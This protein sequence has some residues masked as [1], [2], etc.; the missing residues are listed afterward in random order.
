MRGRPLALLSLCLMLIPALALA[1]PPDGNAAPPRS[2]V[3]LEAAPLFASESMGTAGTIALRVSLTNHTGRDLS[4]E[5]LIQPEGWRDRDLPQRVRVDVP[6]RQQ[7][8]V[9]VSLQ[10]GPAAERV[11]LTYAPA[12]IPLQRASVALTMRSGVGLV[13]L[14]NPPRMRGHL[15]AV[16]SGTLGSPALYGGDLI[17]AETSF[18]PES[19]DPLVPDDVAGWSNYPMVFAA[20]ADAEKLEG[21]A[22]RALVGHIQA[23]GRV[24]LVPRRPEDC[25]APIVRELLGQ[26][27]CTALDELEVLAGLTQNSW[28][29]ARRF[30][31]TGDTSI[32]IEPFGVSRPLGFGTA[33]LLG[34]D[35]NAADADPSATQDL[36]R[37]LLQHHARTMRAQH[38]LGGVPED[39]ASLRTALDPN[40]SFRPALGI[41]AIL[42]LLYVLAV[43]PLNFRYVERQGRPTVALLTTPLIALGCLLLMASAAY[44]SKGV[45]MRARVIDVLELPS[46]ETRGSRTRYVSY[47][48]TRPRTFDAVPEAGVR[49]ML[50]EPDSA[51]RGVVAEVQ[52]GGLAL[53]GLRG[54]LWETIVTQEQS[55][56]DTGGALR[57][58]IRHDSLTQVTVVNAGRQRLMGAIYV[59]AA[60][61]V[62]VLGDLA[63]G[64]Q[65]AQPTSVLAM[66]PEWELRMGRGSSPE[67][68]ATA[69]AMGMPVDATLALRAAM[70][71]MRADASREGVWARVEGNG[72][73]ASSDG[74]ELEWERRF[75]FVAARRNASLP[76]AIP[77][78][79]PEL[80]APPTEGQVTP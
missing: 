70:S 22:R 37:A 59:S 75:V 4:G 53:T 26:V 38:A 41:V 46:G 3:T 61:D 20:V 57:V 39:P 67:V 7:R 8:D 29:R 52:Q 54:G 40:E 36:L 51:G 23:G 5:L 10:V 21:A 74:F 77:Q 30:H 80:V 27:T 43:G 58:D 78:P 68:E 16:S 45:S 44:L 34:W 47:Y 32:Q 71:V 72:D 33:F 2:E 64:E 50:L 24:V 12:G 66:L 63:P 60:G 69:L 11:V 76:L 15:F 48:L 28:Q 55:L 14:A 56:L 65:R 13:V 1:Q 18:A 19:G 49:A 73:G 42:L 17:L 6:A 31:T 9:R 62:Y 35:A 25:D 79:L